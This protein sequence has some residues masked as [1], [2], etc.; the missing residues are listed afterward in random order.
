MQDALPMHPTGQNGVHTEDADRHALRKL[1][2]TESD[3][4]TVAVLG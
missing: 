3:K 4:R 1:E 2:G